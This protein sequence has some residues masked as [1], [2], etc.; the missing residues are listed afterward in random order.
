MYDLPIRTST[1]VV[2]ENNC[3]NIQSHVIY[4]ALVIMLKYDLNI[5]VRGKRPHSNPEM[6]TRAMTLIMVVI[7]NIVWHRGLG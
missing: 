7:D 5:P 3:K 1:V 4:C 2:A 6:L